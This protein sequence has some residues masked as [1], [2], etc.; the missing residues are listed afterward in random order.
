MSNEVL[1][2]EDI[3]SPTKEEI[4]KDTIKG[5]LQ[6]FNFDIPEEQLPYIKVNT[7]KKWRITFVNTATKEEC[8]A[9]YTSECPP[10]AGHCRY[11]GENERFLGQ[12]IKSDSCIR[13]NWFYVEGEREY[14]NDF[15][16]EPEYIPPYSR[17]KSPIIEEVIFSAKTPEGDFVLDIQKDYPKS[18]KIA[19]LE[20]NVYKGTL[21]QVYANQ[22]GD[23]LEPDYRRQIVRIKYG[24]NKDYNY[25]ETGSPVNKGDLNETRYIYGRNMYGLRD[26]SWNSNAL[27]DNRVVYGVSHSENNGVR[28]YGVVSED[29][30]KKFENIRPVGMSHLEDPLRAIESSEV[31]PISKIYFQGYE[32][33]SGYKSLGI[34]KTKDGIKISRYKMDYDDND[35]MARI[36]YKKVEEKDFLPVAEGTITIDELQNVINF[37]QQND[38]ED[39]FVQAVCKE[40][41][42][43]IERKNERKELSEMEFEVS[44]ICVPNLTINFDIDFI[45]DM[46]K[47]QGV[48]NS[49]LRVIRSYADM[50]RNDKNAVINCNREIKERVN[51]K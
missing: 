17:E 41:E 27:T 31:K 14:F 43:F 38:Q 8:S 26:Y 9:Y 24:K 15:M 22:Y 33:T 12:I 13:E 40:L 48:S 3:F 32:R 50:F 36:K 1:K 16:I 6:I 37:L 28:Y 29:G 51:V 21:E 23:V 49:I 42:M 47:K 30:T 2:T 39:K 35:P 4:D 10:Y 19:N 5:V 44:D 25:Y 20:V 46:I 45:T 34:V 7:L 18:D 11:S